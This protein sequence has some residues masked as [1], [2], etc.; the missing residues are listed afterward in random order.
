MHVDDIEQLAAAHI[1]SLER[2]IAALK[3]EIAALR[4]IG[5]TGGQLLASHIEEIAALKA[6]REWLPIADAPKDGKP[7]LMLRK[8][9][10]IR[11]AWW[12]GPMLGFDGVVLIE[13]GWGGDGWWF[14]AWYQ[15]THW[16]PKPPL[17][18]PPTE[19]AGS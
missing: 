3:A 2:E 8:D 12:K 1:D 7:V 10:T 15:P 4:A 14:S 5:Q 9:G 19:D 18:E 13:A 11:E 17:P 6:A 16:M